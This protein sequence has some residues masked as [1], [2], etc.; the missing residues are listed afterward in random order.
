MGWRG[1]IVT[2]AVG[3][4]LSLATVILGLIFIARAIELAF[5]RWFADPLWSALATAGALLLLILLFW[6]VIG[7]LLH[8]R[9][10]RAPAPAEPTTATRELLGEIA[11]L[12][13]D[14]PWAATGAAFAAG[15]ATGRSE[16]GQLLLVELLRQ[17]RRPPT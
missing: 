12:T 16:A 11:A 4:V 2:V 6:L 17:A 10:R 8:R 9:R 13:A 15:I 14:H 1:R 5:F 3:L 7:L